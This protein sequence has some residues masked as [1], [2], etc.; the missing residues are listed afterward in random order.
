MEKKQHNNFK[1]IGIIT[2]STIVDHEECLLALIKFLKKKGKEVLL[3][4]N[5]E[6]LIN[7]SAGLSKAQILNKADLV[8]VLGGDGTLLKVSRQINRRIVPILGV[9]FGTKGFLTELIRSKME[10]GLSKIFADSFEIDKRSLLRVTVYR[11]GKKI[12][13]SLSLNDAVINQG[14]IARLIN[15]KV[16][17]DQRKMITFDADG[18]ILAT[19][20]GSTGHSL[21]A[22][23]PIIHPRIGGMLLTPICPASLS[24]RPILIPTSRQITIVLQ[25][26]R[27]DE[28]TNIGLT[29]DGQECIDLEYGDEIKVRKSKRSL[30]LVRLTNK[31]YYK[32]LRQ[33]L[34]WGSE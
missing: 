30:Y 8:I 14:S 4:S 2:K 1:K 19:P 25:T 22:G 7:K 29:I 16:E 24:I 17:V 15:L 10:E 12:K 18:L 23:G 20:T 28:K 5:A 9:N 31:L 32:T 3:D 6:L 34:N 13:T 21:S 27:R 33:K 26:R 11:K